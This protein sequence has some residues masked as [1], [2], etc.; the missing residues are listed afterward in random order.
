MDTCE[1]VSESDTEDFEDL[2]EVYKSL[3]NEARIA[4]LLQLEK[5]ESVAPLT[6]ELEMTRSGLQK[7]IES[8]ITAGLVYRP[9]DS[10]QTYDL[11]A[12]GE[13]F[14]NEIHDEQEHVGNVLGNFRS[15]L[16]ELRE[17]EQ[18]TLERM[19]DA[20]VDTKE[21]DKKLRAEAWEEIR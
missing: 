3:G 10:D 16:E 1:T 20:G 14:I 18:E 8:L 12:L 11:T 15:Q 7:N 19:K 21:L 2:A 4:V 9:I 5:G 17:E 6:D 13:F